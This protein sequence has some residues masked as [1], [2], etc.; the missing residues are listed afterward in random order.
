MLSVYLVGD[1]TMAVQPMTKRMMTERLVLEQPD[2][3]PVQSVL[4]YHVSNRQF[5]APWQPIRKES[6]YRE[7]TIQE[8]LERQA[9]ENAQG[10]ALHLYLRLLDDPSIIGTV[11]LTNIIY[12]PFLSC[13]LGYS[14]TRA[15]TCHGYMSEAVRQVII[16]AFERYG[17]HRIEA[18]IMPGNHASVRLV[19]K[20]GFVNEGYSSRYLNIAGQWEGHSHFVLLNEAL[21]HQIL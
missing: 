1:V 10:S 17:L 21:E 3:V 6:F 16:V 15:E 14:M 5:H 19:E 9:E 18:N 11:N 4:A 20:L 13:F 12:G 2:G 8:M 7:K